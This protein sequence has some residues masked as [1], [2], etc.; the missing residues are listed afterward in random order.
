MVRRPPRSTL[1]DTLFPDTT[2]FRSAVDREQAVAR[3]HDGRE[4]DL[5]VARPDRAQVLP[6]RQLDEL[7]VLEVVR[8]PAHGQH[9]RTRPDAQRGGRRQS[10]GWRP[11]ATSAPFARENGRLPKKPLWADSGEGCA[12]S[13][14][15][16]RLWSTSPF[17][18]RADAPQR[19]N[20][21]RSG[22]S[23]T[24]L[25]TA[26]VKR[27]QPLPW[28]E[29]ACRAL[30]VSVALSSSTPCRDHASR[31]P[32]SGGSMPRS[33]RSSFMMFCS[34]GGRGTPGRTEKQRP[35]AW[36]GPWYGSWPRTS[37]FTSA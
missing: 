4:V 22:L 10:T 13:I 24:A 31:Q 20:T 25:M 27:S 1:T 2:L 29:A 11:A 7:G 34:D 30:T 26:S 16:W 5:G 19:M 3:T 35:W 28:C 9:G 12:D 23:L 32:W 15:T 6:G 21:T 8:E 37:T 36:P 18:L 14:T 17:F 33:S